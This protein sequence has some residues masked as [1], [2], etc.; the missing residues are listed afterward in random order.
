MAKGARKKT[1][2]VLLTT[3]TTVPPTEKEADASSKLPWETKPRTAV[4]SSDDCNASTITTQNSEYNVQTRPEDQ[5]RGTTVNSSS[6]SNGYRTSSSHHYPPSHHRS[7]SRSHHHYSGSSRKSYYGGSGSNYRSSYNSTAEVRNEQTSSVTINEDEYTKITT[8]RQDVLFKKGYLSRPKKHLSA[9]PSDNVNGSS[10]TTTTTTDGSDIATGSGSVSTAES[11]T[12]DS[13]Y[14][15]DGMFMDSYPTPY[16]YFGYI[17]Q[18][19]VLVMNGFAVDSNGY[20]Y[21]NGGQTYIYPPNYNLSQSQTFEEN[22]EDADVQQ[23][24]SSTESELPTADDGGLLAESDASANEGSD[25]T[26]TEGG[27]E[28][29]GGQTVDD[30]EMTPQQFLAPYANGYDYA[31]FYNNFYYPGCVMAP[32]PVVENAKSQPNSKS[33]E[34]RSQQQP[35]QTT[36]VV[37][38]ATK[39]KPAQSQKIRKKDLIESTRAFAEQNIDLSRPTYLQRASSTRHEEST[40]WRTVCNGKEVEAIEEEDRAIESGSKLEIIQEAPETT[41][42]NEPVVIEEPKPIESKAEKKESKRGKKT[43]KGKGKKAKRQNVVQRQG[44]G[45]EVIEPEFTR[46]VASPIAEEEP[47]VVEEEDRDEVIEEVFVKEDQAEV[48]LVMLNDDDSQT[49][50]EAIEAEEDLEQM[51]QDVQLTD[52]HVEEESVAVSREDHAEDTVETVEEVVESDLLQVIDSLIEEIDEVTSVFEEHPTPVQT[53]DPAPAVCDNTI[54]PFEHEDIVCETCIS[55]ISCSVDGGDKEEEI[56]EFRHFSGEEDGEHVDSGVQSPAAFI[57]PAVAAIEEKK[58]RSY[59]GSGLHVTDAVTKWL[60]E[61]LSST[62]RL[63]ELF[64]LPE[65]PAL[66]HRIQQFHVLN[67]ED[68]LA[69]SS[70]TYSSSSASSGDE[71]DDADSDYMSD[72][73]V[74]KAQKTESQKDQLAKQTANGHL[75]RQAMTGDH[76]NCKQKRCI[77]M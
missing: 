34:P 47:S 33:V 43:A 1:K 15:T 48:E 9:T 74:K 51:L 10:T 71:A 60:S 73:Q 54:A 77:I 46:V 8:P 31:Q 28:E 57:S 66:L 53:E 35:N 4:P 55:P 14:L 59:S 30:E 52:I 11:V 64:V 27:L 76:S 72:V 7:Y 18:S 69:F 50:I 17:D 58:E 21:M 56:E 49:V 38:V 26:K 20:S 24:D 45:F 44:K 29:G 42:A 16:P 12:S 39:P 3:A 13:T 36:S 23:P 65:N 68:S 41:I 67:F 62:T 22:E 32:F 40:T 6:F 75:Q 70:D 5:D 19:G 25:Q 37:A 2:W 63:E 61:T